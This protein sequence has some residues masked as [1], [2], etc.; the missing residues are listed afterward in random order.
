MPRFTPGPW[1]EWGSRVTSVQRLW[2]C[3]YVPDKHNASLI[4]A[5]PDLYD[6]LSKAVADYGKPGGPWNV[7]SEPGTWID[8]A[9]KAL[10]KADKGEI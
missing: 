2:V 4:S 3:G 5:A 1:Q 6:A 7:P 8:M 10:E 9:K